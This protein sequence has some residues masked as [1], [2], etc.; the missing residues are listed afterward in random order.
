LFVRD[1]FG[2]QRVLN[3]TFSP[4]EAKIHVKISLD[5][6]YDSKTI[7][8]EVAFLFA[9]HD[10]KDFSPSMKDES[11]LHSE[12]DQLNDFTRKIVS[13]EKGF[14]DPVVSARYR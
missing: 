6:L 14:V 10:L 7:N 12:V 13:R 3:E 2:V 11:V 9:E 8:M 1:I 4:Y 5:E